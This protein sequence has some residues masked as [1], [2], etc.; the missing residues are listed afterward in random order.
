MTS[1]QAVN[2]FLEQK[3]IAVV[4]VSQKPRDFSR[5]L[6]REFVQRGY[7]VVPVNP[8]AETLEGQRCFARVQDIS[9]RVDGVLLMT[10]PEVTETVVRDCVAAWIK[11]VWMYRARGKGA[12]SSSA[13]QFCQEN[14]MSVIP[15]ECPFMFLPEGGWLHR[16]HG[17]CRKMLGSYPQ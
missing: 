1:L 15:G 9:P 14:G 12:V 3:R 2:D 10:S 16:F 17:A 6:Y 13:V 8:R 7:D 5:L 11:R 4:G